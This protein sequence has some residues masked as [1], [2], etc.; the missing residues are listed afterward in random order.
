VRSS[1]KYL[2]LVGVVANEVETG[3]YYL[4]SRYYNPEWCRFLNA[5]IVLGRVSRLLSHNIFTYCQNHVVRFSDKS[6][7]DMIDAMMDMINESEKRVLEGV[8]TITAITL[9]YSK[10]L[11]EKWV[12]TLFDED[13]S[14]LLPTNMDGTLA[15]AFKHAYWNLQMALRTNT[16]IAYDYATAHEADT[17]R[18]GD[19]PY[20]YNTE[21]MHS[22]MDL[23]YNE[24]GRQL[25]KNYTGKL[26]TNKELA[27]D[28]L[29]AVLADDSN[30]LITA[31]GYTI[32]PEYGGKGN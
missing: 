17:Q 4:R 29:N 30:V 27:I 16:Q 21:K 28:V 18:L 15:N 26:W 1:K 5:D 20:L 10:E 31:Y 23:Y 11:A 32:N 12:N 6:G 19:T 9:F 14:G 13:S 24:L 2:H 25:A 22:D 8:S 3:L 7:C